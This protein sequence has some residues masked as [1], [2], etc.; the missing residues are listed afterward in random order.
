MTEI[1]VIYFHSL[2][3]VWNNALH[4]QLF[5]LPLSVYQWLKKIDKISLKNDS[6]H[7]SAMKGL[8]WELIKSRWG[9]AVLSASIG[10]AR[11]A[12]QLKILAQLFWRK[13]KFVYNT[14]LSVLDVFYWFLPMT[15]LGPSASVQLFF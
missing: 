2:I 10:G 13:R 14:S 3:E 9:F 7:L 15:L 12:P 1:S 11:Y 4:H 8:C 6:L 5:C